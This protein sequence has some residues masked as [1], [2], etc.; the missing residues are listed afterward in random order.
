MTALRFLTSGES[1]GQGM[2]VILEG[3]PAGLKIG[4]EYI[5][6]QLRRRQKGFGAGG[7]QKIESDYAQIKS[8]VRHGETLGSPIHLWIENRDFA[9]WQEA[10]SVGEVGADVDKKAFSNI[11]PGH[12]DFAGALKYTQHDLRNVLERASARETVARMAAGAVAM[13]LLAELG[14][15]LRSRVIAIGGARE[16]VRDLAE[17]DWQAVEASDLRTD[18]AALADEFRK[19]IQNAKSERTT[20]GGVIQVVA[21]GAPV[22]LGSHVHW[23]RK[24]DSRIAGA[25]MSINS[26]KGVEVGTGFANAAKFGR[27][28]QDVLEHSGGKFRKI[29]NHAGG[30]EGGMSNGAPVVVNVAMKPIATMTAPL[31]S[32]DINT[33]EAAPAKYNRSDIC[34][35]PRACPITE[36]V[37]ALTLADSALEKFGGDTVDEMGRNYAE[38][39]KTHEQFGG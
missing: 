20:V 21:F 2:S 6:E 34:H 37:L 15:T 14:I 1:H 31:P 24:L 5:A 28:V 10:M 26:V 11:V 17:I 9:N 7:R 39:V 12:A 29:T 23:D 8:G 16:P 36:A 27:D 19:L 22:G 3:V 13:K 35:V 30:I 4:E 25:M 18:I 32:V 33:G 38:Y